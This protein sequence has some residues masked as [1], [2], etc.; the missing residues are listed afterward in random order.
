MFF[1]TYGG[2]DAA[3]NDKMRSRCQLLVNSLSRLSK[4]GVARSLRVVE[5]RVLRCAIRAGYQSESC[6]ASPHSIWFA[7]AVVGVAWSG[8]AELIEPV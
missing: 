5:R 7:T 1:A 4:H 2:L 6:I 3:A 8:L